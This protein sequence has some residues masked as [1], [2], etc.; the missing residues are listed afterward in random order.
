M[1]EDYVYTTTGCTLVLYTVHLH[2]FHNI[3]LLIFP[4]RIH[5][6]GKLLGVRE[7]VTSQLQYSENQLNRNVSVI[8]HGSVLV[9]ASTYR[10]YDNIARFSRNQSLS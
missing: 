10:L 1:L 9:S 3:L 5:V 4:D 7:N 6:I 8:V 2:D